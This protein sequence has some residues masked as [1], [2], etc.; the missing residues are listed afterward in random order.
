[1]TFDN[2]SFQASWREYQERVLA[3]LDTHLDDDH[4]HIVA[5]PGSG[6]TILGLEVMRRVGQPALI[7]AP[8]IT[9]RNQWIERL[10]S[11]FLP[12]DEERP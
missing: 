1:M 7:L 2:L 5:A 11:L 10:T 3:E 6:K 9:I 4:L 8:T 12:E